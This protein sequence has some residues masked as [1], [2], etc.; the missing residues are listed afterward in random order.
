ML[1]GPASCHH[2]SQSTQKSTQGVGELQE[3]AT[4]IEQLAHRAYSALPEDHIRREAGKAFA[5]WVEDPAIKICLLLVGKKMAKE[6]LRQALELQ[7]MLLA[8]RL[9]K[10]SARSQSPPTR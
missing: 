1:W 6:A 4:A 5:D 2:I 8:A 9:Q 3:F 7:T 10:T